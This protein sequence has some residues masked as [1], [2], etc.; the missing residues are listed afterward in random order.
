[1][2]AAP[3]RR[4]RILEAALGCFEAR[5]VE[6]TTIEEIRR[7][8]GASTG[9][10]YHHFGSKEALAGALYL[11]GL[12]DYHESLSARLAGLE[13]AERVVKAVVLHYA[14]WVAAHPAW[15]RYLLEMRRAASV[16]AVDRERRALTRRYLARLAEHLDPF[17]R[18]G[19]LA[20]LSFELTAAVLLGPSQSLAASWLPQG[21]L[22][23]LRAAAPLLAEVA[24]R[25]VARPLDDPSPRRRTR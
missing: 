5:G 8:S 11:E 13:D 15:A 16:R 19:R 14:D 24:W 25:A 2:G 20:K 7:A 9:S 18:R 6:A 17:V 4:R 21:R 1:M 22:A 3:D 10:L 23:E 12:R